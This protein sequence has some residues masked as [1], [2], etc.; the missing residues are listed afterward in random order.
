MEIVHFIYEGNPESPV[1]F[2]PT[3]RDNVMVNAT[4]MAKIFG[5]EMKDFNKLE[6]T[7]KF[8]ESCL[9]SDFSSLIGIRK[10]E[11]LIISKQNSGTWMHRILALEFATWL[12]PEFKVWILITIDQLLNQY[13]REQRDARLEKI[14]AR[15]RKEQL[16]K[17]ILEENSKF[18]EYVELE[19]IE[20]DS[21]SKIAKSVKSQINQLRL[22]FTLPT[23]SLS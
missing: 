14:R 15:A 3:G 16:R 7:K 2:E 13:F 19:E 21:N 12:D 5:K 23:P 8:I 9:K 11:D 20:K 4:Q 1:D 22:E 6:S 17:E 10:K 18:A